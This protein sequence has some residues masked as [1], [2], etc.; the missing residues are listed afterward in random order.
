M[1]Y[2]G[3]KKAL[4]KDIGATKVGLNN[5]VFSGNQTVFLAVPSVIILVLFYNHRVLIS[6]SE[7]L[8]SGCSEGAYSIGL[9]CSSNLPPCLHTTVWLMKHVLVKFWNTFTCLMRSTNSFKD[10]S[11]IQKV[12][13]YN[14]FLKGNGSVRSKFAQSYNI[15]VSHCE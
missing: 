4:E 6:V 5:W 2:S 10:V 9:Q 1:M 8:E 7:R 14:I 13:F 11:P 12:Q 3:S 15:H